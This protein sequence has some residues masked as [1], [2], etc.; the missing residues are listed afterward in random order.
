MYPT[1]IQVPALIVFVEGPKHGVQTGIC[2]GRR[3]KQWLTG[4]ILL[5][6]H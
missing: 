1:L 2:F 3:L 6:Y 4:K 5:A